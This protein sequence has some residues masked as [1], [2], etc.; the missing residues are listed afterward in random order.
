MQAHPTSMQAHILMQALRCP[1]AS[2]RVSSCKPQ[3]LQRPSHVTDGAVQRDELLLTQT[4]LLTRPVAT[5][6]HQ[7]NIIQLI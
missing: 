7:G 5:E 4:Q 2:T 3:P 6:K 1:H